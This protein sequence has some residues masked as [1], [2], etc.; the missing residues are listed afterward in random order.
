MLP[1]AI[2]SKIFPFEAH[3]I[4][5]LTSDVILERDFFEKF[6]AKIDFDK[7]MIRFKHGE[8]PCLNRIMPSSKSI[9]AQNFSK[10]SLPKITSE[11]KS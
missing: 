11:V 1:F 7:G 9:L 4:L 5:D 3:M 6:C 8:D 2:D 10:K